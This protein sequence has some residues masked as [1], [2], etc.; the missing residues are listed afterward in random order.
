MPQN[1]TAADAALQD[2]YVEPIVRAVAYKT[3]I[4]DRVKKDA[5]KIDHTGRKAVWDFHARRNRGRR[6]I[7]EGGVLPGAGQQGYDSASEVIRYHTYSIELTDAAIEGTKGAENSFVD[8]LQD[9]TEG[10]ARDMKQDIAR[11]AYGDGTGAIATIAAAVT[12]ST[13]TLDTV[14]YLEIGDPVQITSDGSNGTGGANPAYIGAIDYSAKTIT[15]YSDQALT[16]LQ[17]FAA[18]TAMKVYVF[19]N[20]NGEMPGLRN[21]V[22]DNNTLHTVDRSQAKYAY[23]RSRVNNVGGVAGESA[24]QQLKDSINARGQG[25]V[26]EFLTTYGIRRRLAATYTSVKRFNDAQAVNVKGG[27]TAIYVDD[28][29]VLCDPYLPKGDVYAL[30]SDALAWFEQTSPGWLQQ[31]DGAVFNLKPATNGYSASWQAFF[32]WYVTLGALKPFKLGRLTN[33]TDDAAESP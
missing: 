5:S 8:L 31:K 6:T 22:A 9:E 15:L 18:T 30:Q 12:A 2:N 32:R 14:Q 7:A 1:L 20:R 25:E 21:I 27:Y 10:V 26:E 17:S 3:W 24:F 19:G 13:H 11:Q 29:P 16:T 4:L 33:C 28:V 23:L